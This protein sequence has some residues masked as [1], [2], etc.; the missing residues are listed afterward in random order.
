[1]LRTYNFQILS[2]LE[3]EK[4]SRGEREIMIFPP[5]SNLNFVHCPLPPCFSTEEITNVSEVSV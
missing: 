1:M 3:R 5:C 2:V 4:G